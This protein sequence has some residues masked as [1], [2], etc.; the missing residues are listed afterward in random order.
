MT[1]TNESG[2]LDANKL[3]IVHMKLAGERYIKRVHFDELAFGKGEYDPKSSS[4]EMVVMI[5]PTPDGKMSKFSREEFM[6]RLTKELF[7]CRSNVLDFI[8]QG[9]LEGQS[10]RI[11]SFYKRYATL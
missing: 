11:E 7:N 3:A 5:D 4:E 10:D 2:Q 9:E 8:I 6:A 1:T